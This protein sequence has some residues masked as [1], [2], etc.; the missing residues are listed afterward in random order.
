MAKKQVSYVLRNLC[1]YVCKLSICVQRYATS[2]QLKTIK[3]NN[4]YTR[5]TMKTSLQQIL[6]KFTFM[7]I[8]HNAHRDVCRHYTFS[9]VVDQPGP[10]HRLSPEMGVNC[11]PKH[12]VGE[13]K[14]S[15]LCRKVAL[16]FMECSLNRLIP[17]NVTL[18]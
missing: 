5:K 11:S 14:R 6:L 17:N 3:K 8:R 7:S 15:R 2:V 1:A 18:N 12:T 4:E 13:Y 10:A 9:R 16:L